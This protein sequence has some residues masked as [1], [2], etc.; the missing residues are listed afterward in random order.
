VSGSVGEQG[1]VAWW[2]FV[3]AVPLLLALAAWS[4]LALRRRCRAPAATLE[5]AVAELDAALRRA[6]HP[7]PTGTTLRQLERRLGRTPQ[8]AA[9]L[10]ALRHGRYAA[11]APAPTAGGRR[12][13][14]REL[15]QGGGPGA[16]LRALWALPPWRA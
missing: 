14:R 5:R 8:A 7:A 6:G 10:Q 4:V 12:A 1:G 2:W 3:L 13:L 15:A 11:T 16:R 9:Y